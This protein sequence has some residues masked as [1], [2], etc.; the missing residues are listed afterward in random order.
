MIAVV[1]AIRPMVQ[2]SPARLS[3]A[4]ARTT[5]VT[6]PSQPTRRMTTATCMSSARPTWAP[7]F[8]AVT[9]MT[10][11]SW[12]TRGVRSSATA[13]TTIV[14]MASTMA[15]RIVT[16]MGSPFVQVL[17]RLPARTATMQIPPTSRAIS[18]SAMVR[19]TTATVRPVNSPR[20]ATA[21]AWRP[22][23]ATAMTQTRA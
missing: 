11:R 17:L 8:W 2:R 14:S 18:R 6:R 13:S 7:A 4:M 10:T 16:P 20:M 1:T 12:P 23:M 5:T 22:A 15:S 3:S 9:A 21:M 19:T